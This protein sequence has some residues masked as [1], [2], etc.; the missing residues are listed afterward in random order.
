[1][2]AAL[3]GR[4]R[5]PRRRRGGARRRPRRARQGL[6]RRPRPEGDARAPR[7]RTGSASC[8]TR[9]SRMMLTLTPLPQP[10]I[11]RVHGIATAAGCQLVVDV[12]PRGRGGRRALRAARHQLRPVLLDARR[13]GVAPQRR[14][15]SGRSRC[16][17]PASSSTRRRRSTGV[18]STASWPP[19]ELDAAVRALAGI[20]TDK[21]RGG[22]RARA[23]ARSTSRSSAG[24]PAPTSG[25]GEAMTCNMLEPDAAEG[26]DAFVEK[27]KPRW[28]A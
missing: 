4:A 5:P 10:V 3:R 26:V 1:M 6:L 7:R 17:S 14:A 2:L 21:Q 25:A 13:S 11:A 15:A 16:C 22:G 24:S 23:S 12:R 9:C 27:R 8:S 28:N 19:A 20:I 18:S